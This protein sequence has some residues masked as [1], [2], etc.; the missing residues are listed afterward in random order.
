MLSVS[1]GLRYL[2]LCGI[3]GEII[4]SADGTIPAAAAI[5]AFEAFEI[6]LEVNYSCLKG[7]FVNLSGQDQV[8]F[9]VT[10]EDLNESLS[11]DMEEKLRQVGVMS[12]SQQEDDVTYICFTLPRGGGAV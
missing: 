1:E 12:E 4:H 7:V 11:P 3:P 8:M 9:K 5:R 10:F 2:N 6:L